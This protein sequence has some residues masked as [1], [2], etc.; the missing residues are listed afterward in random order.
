[1]SAAGRR[2]P[3]GRGTVVRHRLAS[4]A[5]AG[6]PLGDPS[7][8]EVVVY[9]P[10]GYDA[11]TQ[12][13]K[14]YPVVFVLA[15]YTGRGAMLLNAGAWNEGFDRR[16]DRLIGAGRVRPLIAVLPDCFTRLG[17]SQY[18][19]SSATGRY[20]SYL[21]RELV[22]WV[23]RT[24][25]TRPGPRHRAIAGKSSGGYGAIVQGMK[26]PEVFGSVVDHSGDAA[27]EYCYLPDFPRLLDRLRLHGGV[28]GFLRAFDRAPKKTHVLLQA[29]NILAMASCYSPNPRAG[30]TLGIDLP[31]DLETGA[32]RP[33]VWRRWL[34]N[35][36]VVMA[37][38]HR[39]NLRRLRFVYLDC[40]LRDEFNLNWGARI[41]SR[42]LTRL[43]VAH[44]HQ[45][46][47]DGHMDIP[48]RY[49]VSLP[50]LSEHL[51]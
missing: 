13:A 7:E 47:D 29:M 15:G 39:R 37:A 31:F 17:G 22:P 25:R 24:F 50:L 8:R 16:L 11:H 4:R 26:H 19:D 21:V 9:L 2:P 5:L 14:R 28:R 49:D 6:N 44:V 36:P 43:G 40:G 46:F 10:P 18:L 45:E 34:A 27:F 1:M 51:G 32:L 35:D 38:A 30:E 23:D 48:Y 20:E 42:E 33:R 3:E 41:L 12:R